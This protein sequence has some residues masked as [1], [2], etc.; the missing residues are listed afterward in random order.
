MSKPNVA[1]HFLTL[2]ALSLSSLAVRAEQTV[3][4]PTSPIFQGQS[5]LKFHL[6]APLTELFTLRQTPNEAR[7]ASLKKKLAAHISYTDASGKLVN[8]PLRV[9]LRGN[10]SQQEC[11]FPKMKLTFKEADVKG[12]V[13]EGQKTLDLGTHCSTAGGISQVGRIMNGKDPFREQTIYQIF[14]ALQ[15]D[16]LYSRP[17][18]MTYTDT[19]PGG[20]NTIS[21]PMEGMFLEDLDG[22]MARANATEIDDAQTASSMR[23][24]VKDGESDPYV[25]QNV[26]A[27]APKLTMEDGAI[28][29]FEEWLTGNTDYALCS[30]S[31]EQMGADAGEG[32]CLY[33]MYAVSFKEKQ[34]WMLVVHDFDVAQIVT[35]QQY[36]M[37]WPTY[38]QQAYNQK[39]LDA[40]SRIFLTHK[41]AVYNVVNQ[42]TMDRA[43]QTIFKNWLDTMYARIQ[44]GLKYQQATDNN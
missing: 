13:F 33:N 12:T 31:S 17:A 37:D 18:Y 15:V 35:G 10:T 5:V 24:T 44:S 38:L 32:T 19:S 3:P 29:D 28:A 40:V 42:L 43:G 23:K 20:A 36:N 41:T 27:S 16:H 6:T 11:T 26:R 30:S 39:T 21:H 1:L 34:R 14:E 9:G 8:I 4:A 2:A 7:D 22:F 25:F